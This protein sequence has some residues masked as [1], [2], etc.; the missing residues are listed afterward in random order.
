MFIDLTMAIDTVYVS[1]FRN[2]NGVRGVCDKLIE[3]C[4]TI[5]SQYAVVYDI[6]SEVLPETVGV[7]QG[8]SLMTQ[9]LM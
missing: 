2:F 3:S 5:K 4:L 9:C 6:A 7:S 1:L 8:S